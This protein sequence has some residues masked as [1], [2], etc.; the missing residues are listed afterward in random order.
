MKRIMK[1][2]SALFCLITVIMLVAPHLETVDGTNTTSQFRIERLN[3]DSLGEMFLFSGAASSTCVSEAHNW[4]FDGADWPRETF[5]VIYDDTLTAACSGDQI[6]HDNTGF[7]STVTEVPPAVVDM[8]DMYPVFYHLSLCDANDNCTNAGFLWVE[9]SEVHWY[10]KSNW[11]IDTYL[12]AGDTDLSL[13]FI[14]APPTGTPNAFQVVT[15]D[16]VKE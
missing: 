4:D 13:K 14:W 2:M 1:S 8:S 11:S 7:V 15:Q 9:A 6:T 16:Y 12:G 10:V 3:G 5:I